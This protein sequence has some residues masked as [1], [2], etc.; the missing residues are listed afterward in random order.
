[1]PKQEL[2][3]ISTRIPLEV[4]RMWLEYCEKQKRT[5]YD[6]LQEIITEKLGIDIQKEWI[7][8]KKKG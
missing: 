4:Y 3:Q 5:S 1:M 8:K 7:I 6:M 2:K